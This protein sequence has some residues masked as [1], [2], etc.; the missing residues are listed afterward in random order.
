[1]LNILIPTDFSDNAV[2]AASYALK[3]FG[4]KAQYT[5]LNAFEVPHSGGT[6]LISIADILEKGSLQQLNAQETKHKEDFPELA[7]RVSVRSAMGVPSVMI[8]KLAD[9]REFDMVVM[10]TKGASGIKEVLVGSVASNTLSSVRCPVLAVPEKAELSIPKKILFAADDT[11]LNEGVLPD[12]LVQLATLHDSEVLALNV[13]EMGEMGYV[14]NNPDNV[15]TPIG[16][17]EKVKHS[18][19]FVEA[20]SV[21]AGLDKFMEANQVDMLSMITRREDLIA[22]LFGLSNTKKMIM[23]SQVPLLAFH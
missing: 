6:M 17:F 23:H 11:C 19:H 4:D 2:K 9:S 12:M 10:G 13:V 22:K 16:V 14:G 3:L 21:T 1:M 8:G 15:R 20:E 7:K 18:F 5:L